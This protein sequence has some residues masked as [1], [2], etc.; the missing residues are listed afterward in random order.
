MATKDPDEKFIANIIYPNRT[1]LFT[2][3]KFNIESHLDTSG[4]DCWVVMGFQDFI[5]KNTGSAE[6][7]AIHINIPKGSLEYKGNLAP[8]IPTPPLVKNSANFFKI[9]DTD[10]NKTIDT[11]LE[12]LG[13]KGYLQYNWLD[14]GNRIIGNIEFYTTDVY[15]Q[16]ININ[17]AFNVLNIGKHSI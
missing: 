9:I 6:V 8:G 11:L 7:N 1:E 14:S 13:T 5:N 16:P 15:G 17:G 2:A 4:V 12:F 3:N 10:E